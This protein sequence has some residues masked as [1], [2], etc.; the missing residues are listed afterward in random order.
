MGKGNWANE[1]RIEL[2]Q[3]G[4]KVE[5]YVRP[6]FSFGFVDGPIDG[7]V[8]GD[9]F[10]FEQRNGPIDGEVR[11]SGDE[12]KGYLNTNKTGPAPILLRRVDSSAPQ[13]SR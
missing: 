4:G 5:G 13:L 8:G 6:H 7:A 9:V 11:A 3:H 12:M 2:V 10:T 1:V